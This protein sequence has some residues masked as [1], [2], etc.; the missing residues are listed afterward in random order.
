MNQNKVVDLLNQALKD[1]YEAVVDVFD[2][3][4]SC[5]DK[6]ADSN[7]LVSSDN[8]LSVL[9]ILNSVMI[10]LEM[11]KIVAIWDQH[12]KIVRFER[13]EDLEDEDEIC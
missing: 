10:V 6:L 8:T 1:D 2:Y 3:R 4:T 13:D 11:D 12:G 5:N 9:G 7:I